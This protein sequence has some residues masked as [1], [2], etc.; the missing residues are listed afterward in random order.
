MTLLIKK[1]LLNLVENLEKNYI[2]QLR[3]VVNIKLN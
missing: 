2:C 1:N 3:K